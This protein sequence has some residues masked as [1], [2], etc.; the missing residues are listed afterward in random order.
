MTI[1]V[2]KKKIWNPKPKVRIK[3]ETSHNLIQDLVI[4]NGAKYFSD[5]ESHI[6]SNYSVSQ[7]LLGSFNQT[8]V[9][10]KITSKLTATVAVVV[11]L[12][13]NGIC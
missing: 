9:S 13:E 7:C 8:N 11:V 3:R 2:S 10:K 1:L 4:V 12:K 6:I 5:G